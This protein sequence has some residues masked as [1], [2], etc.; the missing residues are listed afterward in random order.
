M[1]GSGPTLADLLQ[2]IPDHSYT[3]GESIFADLAMT[4]VSCHCSIRLTDVEASIG[5]FLF[6]YS[7]KRKTFLCFRQEV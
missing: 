1:Q 4:L 7:C 3:E 5:L 2:S 6:T